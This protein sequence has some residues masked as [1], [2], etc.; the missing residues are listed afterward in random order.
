MS[1]YTWNQQLALQVVSK[2]AA[3][4][5]LIGSGYI[6]HS[7]LTDA[8]RRI[9]TKDRLITAMSVFDITFSMTYIVGPWAFPRYLD[10]VRGAYGTDRTCAAEGFFNYLGLSVV[11]YNIAM[12][13]YFVLV[14]K[15]ERTERQMKQVEPFFLALP[16][17]Y[18]ALG[19]VLTVATG[20]IHAKGLL[21]MVAPNP[22]ECEE[23]DTSCLDYLSGTTF[24]LVLFFNVLP[25]F[26]AILLGAAA[27]VTLYCS[28]RQV[29]ARMARYAGGSQLLASKAV[30]IQGA[31]FMLA[32]LITWIPALIHNLVISLGKRPNFVAHLI[33]AATN[34][35][36]GKRDRSPFPPYFSKK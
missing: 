20:S 32:L 4:A 11:S 12:A 5:S 27:M 21:C 15:Y 23:G 14:V 6:V 36:Q 16:I 3:A 22:T 35:L 18:S 31:L 19:A 13:I 8:K 1:Q 24:Y 28:V 34:P 10:N 25:I 9:A 30:G 26:I 17:G 33:G 29:E 2:V 7:V